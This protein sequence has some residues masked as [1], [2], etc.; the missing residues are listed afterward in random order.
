M[1]MTFYL[2]GLEEEVYQTLLR[3]MEKH[4]RLELKGQRATKKNLT[5]GPTTSVDCPSYHFKPLRGDLTKE[6]IMALLIELENGDISFAE[7]KQE[8]SRVKE[9]KEVQRHLIKQTGSENWEE[10]EKR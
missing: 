8:A 6:E 5:G 9:I 1:E 4:G 2:S 10:V 3:V 7:M